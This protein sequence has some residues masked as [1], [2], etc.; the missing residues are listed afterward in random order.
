MTK[1]YIRILKVFFFQEGTDFPWG[2]G[3]QSGGDG[4]SASDNCTN[5]H[6]PGASQE[7]LQCVDT[8]AVPNLCL[9]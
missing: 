2:V 7:L 9:Q 5:L 8:G 1:Q 3:D 4:Q 6:R